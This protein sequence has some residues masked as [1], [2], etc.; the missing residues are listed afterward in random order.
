MTRFVHFVGSLPPQLM[1]S[2]TDV[3]EWFV[4]RSHGHQLTGVPC[5]LDP[6]WVVQYLRDREKHL[7]VFEVVRSG[8]FADYSDMRGYGVR[9][10]HTLEPRHVSMDRAERIAEAVTAFRE[11]Q[12]RHPELAGT[13][14]QISQPN[15]LDMALFVFAGAAVADG[16]PLGRALR[17]GGALTPALRNL[18]VFAEAVLAEMAELTAEYGDT[19]TWQV[20]S[21]IAQLALVK[22]AQLGAH[23]PVGRLVARQLAGFL[24]GAHDIGAQTVL[25]LCYGDYQHKE[26]L[27]PRT[28]A[29]A[30]NLLNAT[31]RR[32]RKRG[33]PLPPAHIPCAYGA[34]PAPLN[35]AFYR[36]LR[37]LNEDWQ[38]IAGVVSPA[39]TQGSRR[40]LALFEQA[41]GRTAYG[42]ATAC[43]LGRSTVED[44]EHAAAA[45]VATAAGEPPIA[46][47]D[48]QTVQREV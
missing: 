16:L 43:G 23:V 39:D 45:T 32:L 22:A 3:L 14:L 2:D 18:P 13:R 17:H 48:L 38:L 36:P 37:R 11:V 42:V 12:K 26:L 4:Q 1:T 19:L 25:H 40:S 7:D 44:A 10:G 21:P 28:I 5:D 31:A 24:E 30:V 6:N 20:E 47:S 29:P 34:H 46:P 15:P 9:H 35:S 27:A 33:V 41:S 8:D